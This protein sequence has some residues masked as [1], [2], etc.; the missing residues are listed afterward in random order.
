MALCERGLRR[1][2][3]GSGGMVCSFFWVISCVY[4]SLVVVNNATIYMRHG[5]FRGNP[6]MG[7]VRAVCTQR[8]FILKDHGEGNAEAIIHHCRD[9]S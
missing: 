6:F 5:D 2:V 9:H 4:S 3:F 7:R 1:F 8:R